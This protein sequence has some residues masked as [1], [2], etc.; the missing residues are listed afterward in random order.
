[1]GALKAYATAVAFLAVVCLPFCLLALQ[2]GKVDSSIGRRHIRLVFICQFV[3][4][5]ISKKLVYGRLGSVNVRNMTTAKLW[6]SLCKFTH[7]QHDR[8]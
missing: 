6:S 1:M 7:A 4:S 8:H 3:A 5:S 2:T